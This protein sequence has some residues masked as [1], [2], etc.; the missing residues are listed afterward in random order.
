MD[1]PIKITYE[2]SECK[3]S[4]LA[5]FSKLMVALRYII[6]PFRNRLISTCIF[7]MNHFTLVA[8]KKL[9]AMASLCFMPVKALHFTHLVRPECCSGSV[10]ALGFILLSFYYLFLGKLTITTGRNGSLSLKGCR[11]KCGF[12][13]HL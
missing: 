13:N 2:I 1:E 7:L 3:S 5:Y 12:Q 9:S 4:F 8:T 6:L 10:Y 11:F